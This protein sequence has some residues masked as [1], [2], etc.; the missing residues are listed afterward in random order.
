M[1]SYSE[2]DKEVFDV[3]FNNRDNLKKIAETII[4]AV[5]DYEL[6]NELFMFYFEEEEE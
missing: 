5:S 4:H 3:F 1:Q 2:L 6:G